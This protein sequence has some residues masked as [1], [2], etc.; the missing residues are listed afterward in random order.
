MAFCTACGTEHILGAYFCSSCGAPLSQRQPKPKEAPPTATVAF[1]PHCGAEVSPMPKSK[2]KCPSC[3][4]V[5]VPRTLVDGT[6]TLLTV[7]RAAD[8]DREKADLVEERLLVR[9]LQ[10]LGV[11]AKERREIEANLQQQHGCPPSRRDIAW[12]AGNWKVREAGSRGAFHEVSRAYA[13][14][15]YQ[16]YNQDKDPFRM[17][18]LAQHF[19]LIALQQDDYL[20]GC[21]LRVVGF[22]PEGRAHEARLYTFAE[23]FEQMP[24]PRADCSNARNAGGYGIC[25]CMYMH[26]LGT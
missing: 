8:L 5:I 16:L 11:S 24:I 13:L 12:Q 14:M 9:Q 6:K 3:R 19:E 15:A 7:D 18:K 23:A 26:E 22:C 25:V 17:T 21:K 1:C 20:T 4:E 10:A 2:R